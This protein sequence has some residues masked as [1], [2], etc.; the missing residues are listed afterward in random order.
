MVHGT[1]HI[2]PDISIFLAF[3][4]LGMRY[5]DKINYVWQTM[6]SNIAEG[7]NGDNNIH[8]YHQR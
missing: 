2:A 4:I 7:K 3:S 1:F 5:E 8:Y 6:K